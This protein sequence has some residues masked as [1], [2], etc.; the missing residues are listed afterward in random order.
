MVRRVTPLDGSMG[1]D[2]QWMVEEGGGRGPWSPPADS[3]LE[4]EPKLLQPKRE[5][6]LTVI[7]EE[8]KGK[9]LI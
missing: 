6:G 9:F 4:I 5:K 1:E 7:L 8:L 2:Q 3:S